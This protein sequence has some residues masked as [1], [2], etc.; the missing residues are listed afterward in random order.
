MEIDSEE[1]VK[2]VVDLLLLA[3]SRNIEISAKR[4][5]KGGIVC[6]KALRMTLEVKWRVLSHVQS[7]H[8]LAVSQPHSGFFH[9]V[10]VLFDRGPIIEQLFV[11]I[12]VHIS[13]IGVLGRAIW[14]KRLFLLHKIVA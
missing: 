12:L 14:R 9:I 4:D 8:M 7:M 1:R 6:E 5:S 10:E 3:R 2:C 13:S 11:G